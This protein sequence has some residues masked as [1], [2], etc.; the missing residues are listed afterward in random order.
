M[1][2]DQRG[3]ANPALLADALAGLTAMPKRLP[4]KW[5][6]DREGSELFE[7]IT[8]LPGYYPT[9]TEAAILRDHADAL[10]ATVPAGGALVEYGS[11]ASVKTRTLLDAGGHFG[12]YVP[13]DISR[14]FLMTTADDLRARY[15]ALPVHPV[16]GDFTTD[17]ALPRAV[18]GMAKTGFF[19]GSTIGNLDLSDATA[20]LSRARA[21]PKAEAFILGADLVKDDAALLAA[22][23]DPEGVTARFIGG[24]LRRLRDEAD[25]EIDPDAFRYEAVWN[26]DEA[27]IDMRLVSTRA[28]TVRLPGAVVAFETDEPIHV[29]TSRKYTPDSLA[30][31]AASGGWR[32]EDT[33]TDGR[34]WFAVAVLCPA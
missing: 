27:K 20:L 18:E 28:Q 3:V 10:A 5:F 17:V 31:L 16:V 33:L 2:D 9:R 21:W 1:P 34:G 29:S 24:V 32:V 12:A 13:I 6:Y 7:R 11:G 30:A 15:P 25:A 19:P 8:A 22:Y 4:P 23:D 26:A 14:D